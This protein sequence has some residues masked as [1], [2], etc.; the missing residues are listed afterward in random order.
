M[1][2]ASAGVCSETQ[3][4]L[5]DLER[6]LPVAGGIF[7]RRLTRWRNGGN[8]LCVH[9]AEGFISFPLVARCVVSD[10]RHA[11]MCKWRDV[12]VRREE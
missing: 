7:M 2:I 10:R 12:R 8:L 6:L 9:C 11:R 5:Y 4:V 3:S 1:R